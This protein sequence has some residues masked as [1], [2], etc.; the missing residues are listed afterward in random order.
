M[1]LKG[2]IVKSAWAQGNLA[3]KLLP[4]QAPAYEYIKTW[5]QTIDN[6]KSE[7]ETNHDAEFPRGNMLLLEC[8][9]RFGK[10]TVYGITGSEIA[11]TKPNSLVRFI[12][13]TMRQADEI[14]R[15]IFDDIFLDCPKEFAP[16]WKENK[17]QYVFPNGSKI[18][19]N[20][21][22]NDQME[23]QRGLRSDA[24]FVTEIRDISKLEYLINDILLPQ[25][26]T[27]QAP[28]FFDSTP[29]KDMTHYYYALKDKLVLKNASITFTLDD[30][31]HIPQA[32][33]KAWIDQAGGIDSPTVQREYFCKRIKDEK[34]TV[35]PEWK[36]DYV[37]NAPHNSNFNYYH[38]YV[39]LDM[40]V[41]D[42][43]SV[44]Y[45]Y[46]DFIDA[47]LYIIDEDVLSG[48]QLTTEII[49]GT[50]KDKEQLLFGNK[51]T[52]NNRIGQ[53]KVFRRIADNTNPQLLNDLGHSYGLSFIPTTKT[54]LQAMVNKVRVW[55]RAGRVKIDQKCKYAIGCIDSAM[56]QNDKKDDFARSEAFKHYDALAAIVYL[57][58]AIDESSNP[59]PLG[60]MGQ[61]EVVFFEKD[62][63]TEE[64][65]IQKL[66]PM[67]RWIE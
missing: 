61:N 62:A 7:I 9:R 8:H 50:I 53:D 1:D 30:N 15:P 25:T 60:H 56:W 43:T 3:Y 4:Y 49:S 5:L 37:V 44:L 10:T 18:I 47:T 17:K 59:L 40:G 22:E 34:L 45:A 38:K 54:N 14:L 63:I 19:I 32:V 23:A 39:A 2:L 6:F 12:A 46:Y 11:I 36:E 27:T 33:K 26:M 52:G 16:E 31:T 58:R 29:A 67:A 51:Y 55:V 65:Q 20:G 48:D 35:I 42:N 28:I 64:A 13:P 41:R 24:T 57:V 66:F 21:S